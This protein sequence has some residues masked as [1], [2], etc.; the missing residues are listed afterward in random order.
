MKKIVFLFFA[1][2]MVLTPAFA[3][4]PGKDSLVSFWEKSL[5]ENPETV[6]FAADK[7]KGVYEFETTFFPYK[8]RLKLLNAA[9]AKTGDTYYEGFY[10]GIIEIELLDAPKNFMQKY[11]Q[12]Y[13]AWQ[14]QNRFFYSEKTGKWFPA[15]QWSENYADTSGDTP[16]AA[17]SC[18]ISRDVLTIL[19][20]IAAIL[21]LIPFIRKQHKRAWN[22]Q[23]QIMERQ[24]RSLD[25]SEELLAVQKQ[26]LE[27][28]RK[29]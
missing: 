25:I 17:R 4:P 6:V 20:L 18:P 28:L 13:Y 8:G 27:E 7:E 9:V 15:S 14:E 5:K 2:L 12:S 22:A 1:F 23:D 24:K 10:T 11:A 21:I 16:A 26:I 19:V 29:K 3:A